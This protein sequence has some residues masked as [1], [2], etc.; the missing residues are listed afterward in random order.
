[1]RIAVD[2]NCLAWG[3]GGIPK[4]VDRIVRELAAMDGVRIALLANTREPFARIAGTSEVRL[5]RRGGA[6]WRNTFVLPWLL[7]N[8]PDVFWAPETALPAA[9]PVPTVVTIH[10]LAPMILP[11]IKPPAH[12]RAFRRM[13]RRSAR[14]ATRVIAVS[15]TTAADAERLWGISRDVVRVVPNGVDEQFVP[16]PRDEA[17]AVVHE[18]HGV[19]RPYVLAVGAL[20]PRKG[21]D[22]LIA[23]A[24]RA[25]WQLVLAGAPGFGGEEIVAAARAAGAACLGR[26]RDEEL[27]SLYSGAIALAAPSLYEGF[28]MTPLEAMRCGTPTV[29]SNAAGLVEISG[30][31]AIV[32][33]E[34]SAEAWLAG[35]DEA[36]RRRDE[37]RERGFA[38]AARYRWRDVAAETLDVL[39]EAAAQRRHATTT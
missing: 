34:R 8:R 28:G 5:R 3:W 25:D 23:A 26:V 12:H 32:V 6:L 31:A 39:R 19:T 30:D 21:L 20:E 22:V 35:I 9:A 2:A 13:L 24:S 38:L 29:V 36:N 16:V 17:R 4:H 37:L 33:R 15:K 27:V 18:R 11:S 14:S 10:D 7:R 1:M